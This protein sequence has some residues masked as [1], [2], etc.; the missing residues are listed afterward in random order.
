[1]LLSIVLTALS[2]LP[3]EL[4][5]N[6]ALQQE[7]RTL[8]VTGGF[9]PAQQSDRKTVDPS[10]RKFKAD[11]Q[12]QVERNS[13]KCVPSPASPEAARPCGQAVYAIRRR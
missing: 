7:H 2:I 1:M 13:T 4:N 9:R 8:S 11:P 5:D 3:L 10:T 12:K 6:L